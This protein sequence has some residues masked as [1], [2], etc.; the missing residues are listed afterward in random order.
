MDADRHAPGADGVDF[1]RME[2]A[3]EEDPDLPAQ[4]AWLHSGLAGNPWVFL[5]R[6]TDCGVRIFRHSLGRPLFGRGTSRAMEDGSVLVPAGEPIRLTYHDTHG[7]EYCTLTVETQ[8]Q[9]GKRY[10]VVGASN[11]TGHAS[12]F[13]KTGD[14]CSL[15][16]RDDETEEQVKVVAY[17]QGQLCAGKP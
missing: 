1:L 6:S 4:T 17:R 2:I 14:G 9:P 12:A 11:M 8:L 3:R 5:D 15:G 13:F 10:T 7:S 16:L